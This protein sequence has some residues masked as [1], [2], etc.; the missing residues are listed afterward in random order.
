MTHVPFWRSLTFCACVLFAAPAWGEE[1][2]DTPARPVVS[3]AEEASSVDAGSAV[4]RAGARAL[5]DGG[6]YEEAVVMLGTASSG[7]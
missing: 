7:R 4:S 5:V 6:R 1:E 3:A 2:E